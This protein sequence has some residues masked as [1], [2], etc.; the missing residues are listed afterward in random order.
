VSARSDR[1]FDWEI[2]A[3]RDSEQT[4]MG[5]HVAPDGLR[6]TLVELNQTYAPREVVVTE[7]GAAY[8]DTVERD[9]RVHDEARV[10]YLAHHVAAVADAL[11][12]GV[13]VTGYYVWSFL[14]NYE[15]SLGYTRRFGL[16]HVDF[17]SQRRTPKDSARW[18]QRLT[19]RE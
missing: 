10:D 1:V 16:V 4:Q 12:T 17:E 14:D 8:P 9:G 13:P 6:D 7:N 18:Y 2:G 19:A 11:G 5:W 3:V 15:W